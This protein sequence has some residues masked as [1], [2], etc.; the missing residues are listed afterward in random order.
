MRCWSNSRCEYIGVCFIGCKM[1]EGNP[2]RNNWDMSKTI[3]L[4]ELPIGGIETHPIMDSWSYSSSA[5][6]WASFLQFTTD[7]SCSFCI[8]WNRLPSLHSCSSI[9]GASCCCWAIFKLL[10]LLECLV[11]PSL[12][13]ILWP[14]LLF[15]WSPIQ[16]NLTY[17][18]I[19]LLSMHY[20]EI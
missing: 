16:G 2:W 4:S 5:L 17:Y 3:D 7:S 18:E 12:S 13:C 14:H 19:I 6:F 9:N 10:P 20:I 15:G 11:Q 8:L 1:T